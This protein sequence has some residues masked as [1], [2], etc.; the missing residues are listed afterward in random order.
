MGEETVCTLTVSAVSQ[1]GSRGRTQCTI[2]STYLIIF[3]LLTPQLFMDTPVTEDTLCKYIAILQVIEIYSPQI[4]AK[5]PVHAQPCQNL[6]SN[7]S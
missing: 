7:D 3:P 1:L 4:A 5:S 6:S 2:N